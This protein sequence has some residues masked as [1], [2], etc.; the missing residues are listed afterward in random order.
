M[1]EKTVVVKLKIRNLLDARIA[2]LRRE[3]EKAGVDAFFYYNGNVTNCLL[4]LEGKLVAKGIAICSPLDA[5]DKGVGKRLALTRALHALK[6]QISEMPVVQRRI[7]EF[8]PCEGRYTTHGRHLRNTV[9]SMKS[10]FLPMML[11]SER[12]LIERRRR[13][14]MEREH[15]QLEKKA[16]EIP[17]GED[18]Q[19]SS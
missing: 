9:A 13:K 3:V 19:G 18:N 1:V 10:M 15:K 17:V 2:G 8:N 5:P 16:K 6:K 11:D 4:F 12:D 7:R 14:R